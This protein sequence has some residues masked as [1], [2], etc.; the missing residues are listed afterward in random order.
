MSQTVQLV[1]E[2]TELVNTAPFTSLN[3]VT[4]TGAG[5]AVQ[6]GSVR[7]NH[8]IQVVYTS[9]PTALVVNLE[10]SLDGTHWVTLGSWSIVG[11]QAS[12]D[13]VWITGKAAAWTRAN[14]ASVTG[15]TSPAVT[16]TIASA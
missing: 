2:K 12:G 5:S 3:A 9:N 13:I 1:N 6:L 14:W 4:A 11:G 8:A 15:G 10:G 16:A 7:A